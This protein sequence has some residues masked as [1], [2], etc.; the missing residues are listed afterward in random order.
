MVSQHNT[1]YCIFHIHV[2][3]SMMN[4]ITFSSNKVFQLCGGK[5]AAE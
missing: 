5:G 2:F 4:I 3:W 1:H